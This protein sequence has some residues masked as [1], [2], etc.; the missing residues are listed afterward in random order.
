MISKSRRYVLVAFICAFSEK[1]AKKFF[2]CAKF[3]YKISD[4]K[5]NERRPYPVGCILPVNMS[6][7]CRRPGLAGCIFLKAYVLGRLY[8]ILL[9]IFD[10]GCPRDN[11]L[12]N[13]I[14]V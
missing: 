4:S 3:C 11:S 5:L 13:I 1:D 7:H 2:S 12:Y 6:K 9:R 10:H 14:P 8:I